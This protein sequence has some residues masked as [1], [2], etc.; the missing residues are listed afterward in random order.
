MAL[1]MPPPVSPI[2]LGSCVKK[3]RFSPLI[4]RAS[5]VPKIRNSGT[6]TSSIAREIKPKAR[7]LVSRR[8]NAMFCEE[9]SKGPRRHSSSDGPDQKSGERVDNQSQHKQ[10]KGHLD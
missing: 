8:C 2:G 5:T 6:V 4:P 9:L 10:D 3:A 7:L 1:T